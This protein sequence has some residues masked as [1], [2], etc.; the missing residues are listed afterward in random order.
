MI[1]F[2]TP[3][4]L[5]TTNMHTADVLEDEVGKI[6]PAINGRRIEGYGC[7]HANWRIRGKVRA[8][9]EKRRLRIYN[10]RYKV[11]TGNKTEGRVPCKGREVRGTRDVNWNRNQDCTFAGKQE[12]Y[13]DIE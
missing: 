4:T 9:K 11:V 6:V 8:T 10:P 13:G 3:S 1:E 2:I 7:R 5:T 12:L